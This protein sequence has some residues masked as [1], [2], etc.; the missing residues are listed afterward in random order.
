MQYASERNA[1]AAVV[2]ENTRLIAGQSLGSVVRLYC[3]ST[4]PD[5]IPTHSEGI[6]CA[7]VTLSP[8]VIQM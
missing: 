1:R 5:A 3:T 7:A 4:S 6:R 8:K 2:G